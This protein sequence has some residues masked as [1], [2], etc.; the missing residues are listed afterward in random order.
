MDLTPQ[1]RQLVESIQPLKS[2]HTDPI[3]ILFIDFYCQCRQGCDYLFPVSMRAS[4]RLLDILEWFLDCAEIGKLTPLVQLM[5][6]DVVGPT[7]GEYL[8][9]EKIESRLISAF[10][11][12]LHN[13]L[14]EWDRVSLPGGSVRLTLR[15]LLADIVAIEQANHQSQ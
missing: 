13:S 2:R 3:S 12:D 5:W 11:S 14:A 15:E 10:Q 7:L 6:K 1:T 8:E 4:I 9:D